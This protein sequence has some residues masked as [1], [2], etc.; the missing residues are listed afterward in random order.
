MLLCYKNAQKMDLNSQYICHV[1]V[2]IDTI[3]FNVQLKVR[4]FEIT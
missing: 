2:N 3:V 1:Y 4:D